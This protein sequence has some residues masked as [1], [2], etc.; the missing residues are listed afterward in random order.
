MKHE[1]SETVAVGMSGGVDS[2]I[3]AHLL[4]QQGYRVIG[5]TMQIW[6][7]ALE[8]LDS[9]RAACYGPGE[10]QDIAAAQDVARRLGIEHHIIPLAEEYKQEVL[11]YFRREYRAG[12]TPN[13]CVRCNHSMKF[14]FLLQKARALGLRFDRFATGHYARV[15][16]EHG[17]PSLLR[18]VDPDKDQSYF[19]SRLTREQLAPLLLPLGAMTKQQVRAVAEQLGWNDLA[20]KHESQ[21]FIESDSYSV[22]F[23]PE[24]A[25]PGEIRDRQGRVLGEHRGLIHYTVGQRKGIGLS[26]APHPLYVLNLDDKSNCVTV[27]PREE[28]FAPGFTASELNWIELDAMPREPLRIEVKIRQKSR[29]AAALLSPRPGSEP[30]VEVAFDEPQLSVTPGQAAVFYQGDRVIGSGTIERRES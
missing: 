8:G 17:R 16:M 25:R 21:D 24:D 15:Q 13:P 30:S 18:A 22:L 14:G 9:N 26:G 7:G 29:P 11:E 1:G 27:G 12:R 28:L 6:D 20:E 23:S 2:S 5:L 10:E 3:A 19:L 4:L